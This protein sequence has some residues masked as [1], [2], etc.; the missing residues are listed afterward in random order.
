MTI[1]TCK[2]KYH[3]QVYQYFNQTEDKENLF[4]CSKCITEDEGPAFK[5]ILTSD[6]L[7]DEYTF[8]QINN[9]PPFEKKE[10]TQFVQ[11]YYKN[12]QENPEVENLLN[13]MIQ[14]QIDEYFEE[15]YDIISQQLNKIKK[16]VKIQFQNKIYEFIQQNQ[17]EGKAD[18][19]EI[20]KDL[21]IDNFRTKL[22]EFLDGKINLDQFHI[23]Q[24]K[25]TQNIKNKQ[26]QLVQTYYNKQKDIQQDFQRLQKDFESCLESFNQFDFKVQKKI[27]LDFS[28][29]LLYTYQPAEGDVISE[30]MSKITLSKEFFN[31][32]KRIYTTINQYDTYHI[33]L[34]I[35]TKGK[36][37][38]QII[39]FGFDN[40][41]F[42]ED[43]DKIITIFN[44][45]GKVKGRNFKLYGLYDN[46]CNIFKDNETVLNIVFNFGK[47]YM[48][49]FDSGQKI[50]VECNF[51][52]LV[53]DGHFYFGSRFI[54][55][56]QQ[57]KQEENIIY[58]DSV[59]IY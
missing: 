59:N 50:K 26:Q 14:I 48:E 49:V 7:S 34:R 46:F 36:I 47:K 43:T 35:D 42:V 37:Y 4:Q 9:W 29:I 31:D 18:L 40:S 41:E 54:I 10:L 57:K 58:I 17:E 1:G 45:N 39:S 55:D 16:E 28:S 27:N 38:H 30:D 23:F 44:E 53:L 6:I 24:Q 51:P 32:T 52:E 20:I 33:K 3:D 19:S 11:Q 22:R 8:E 15:Q 2:K 13:H 25:Y 5:K 56:Y 21:K 12:N